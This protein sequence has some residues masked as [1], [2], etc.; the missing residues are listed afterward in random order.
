M[1]AFGVLLWSVLTWSSFGSKE[2]SRDRTELGSSEDIYSSAAH[3]STIVDLKGELDIQ[4]AMAALNASANLAK[5]PRDVTERLA[6]LLQVCLGEVPT[7]SEEVFAYACR[8]LEA[9]R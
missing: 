2:G 4:K 8:E 6:I 3:P 7:S 9:T 1:Y 5:V